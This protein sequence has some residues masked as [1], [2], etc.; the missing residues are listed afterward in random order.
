MI[1]RTTASLRFLTSSAAVLY[2]LPALAEAGE[3]TKP[4]LPQLYTTLFPEQLFWLAVTF[5]A[6][7]LLMSFVALPG[8][9]RTQDNRQATIS[10]EVAAAAAAHEQAKTMMEEYERAL[11][12]A[13]AEAHATVTSI[14]TQAAKESAEQQTT[15]RQALNKRLHEAE[16]QISAARDAAIRDIH[17]SAVEL[18]HGLIEKVTGFKASTSGGRS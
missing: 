15:Q 1:S 16:A 18:G 8:V 10:S 2:T 12:K 4:G 14:V 17:S 6:L 3:G 11:A 7:Y 9:R 5:S 13:R